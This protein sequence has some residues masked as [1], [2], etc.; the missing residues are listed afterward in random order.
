[1][2]LPFAPYTTPL[3]HAPPL[4]IVHHSSTPCP[5][6]LHRTP[7]IYTM[8]LPSAPYTTPLRHAPPLCTIR[9]SSTLLPLPQNAEE[10]AIVVLHMAA[11]N[12]TGVDPDIDQWKQIADVIK[13]KKLFPIF[14]SAY[15]G[16]A[17]GDLERD[18]FPARFFVSKGIELFVAQSFSKNFGLYSK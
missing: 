11:H 5:S 3:R 4:C 16:F 15:Q 13:R 8:P 2:P 9:H 18:A 1:M 12:P 7:L 10:G 17:S 6:P 14:D